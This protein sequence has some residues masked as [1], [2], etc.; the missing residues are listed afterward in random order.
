MFLKKLFQIIIM[1]SISF[2]FR[3][4]THYSTFGQLNRF[5]RH[6]PSGKS[7]QRGSFAIC[8]IDFLNQDYLGGFMT[9]EIKGRRGGIIGG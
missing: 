3:V 7:I 5:L 6:N 8:V 4:V 1:E 9:H 2:L